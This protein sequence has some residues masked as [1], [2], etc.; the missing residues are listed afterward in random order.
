MRKVVALWRDQGPIPLRSC[1]LVPGVKVRVRELVKA[2]P[3]LIQ[4]L[5]LEEREWMALATHSCLQAAFRPL[6]FARLALR[7]PQ[8]QG[9]FERA[10]VRGRLVQP[11]QVVLKV[12]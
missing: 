2:F 11:E 8:G 12:A 7:K 5:E 3:T 6:H 4:T 9:N 1:S 10:R